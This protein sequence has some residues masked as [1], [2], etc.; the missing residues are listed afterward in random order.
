MAIIKSPNEIIIIPWV[1][2][3][4]CIFLILKES[5]FCL[6]DPSYQKV[7][8][9]LYLVYWKV[10]GPDYSRAKNIYFLLLLSKKYTIKYQHSVPLNQYNTDIQNIAI[11]CSIIFPPTPKKYVA[12]SIKI[13]STIIFC[14]SLSVHVC[15]CACVC[16]GGRQT[17]LCGPPWPW[18]W[19]QWCWGC[20]GPWQSC[21]RFLRT[22]HSGGPW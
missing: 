9:L 7:S 3:K 18:G 8:I 1:L 17:P 6:A 5:P 2:Q 21:P 22:P 20:P 15:V 4:Q 13:Q 16:V 14:N 10:S 11:L 12:S 19:C